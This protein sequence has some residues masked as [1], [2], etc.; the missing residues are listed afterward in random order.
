MNEQ[1][2]INPECKNVSPTAAHQKVPIA[3]KSELPGR[4]YDLS[5]ECE[6]FSFPALL[7]SLAH[8][9]S[10]T[11]EDLEFVHRLNDMDFFSFSG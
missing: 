7:V 9:Q 11:V 1:I 10:E 5:Y 8:E 3:E 2:R 6:L 4:R